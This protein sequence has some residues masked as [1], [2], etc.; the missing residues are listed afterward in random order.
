MAP[1]V[2]RAYRDR[3]HQ[4]AARNGACGEASD[5]YL[6]GR[7]CDPQFRE[8]IMRDRRAINATMILTIGILLIALIIYF[9]PQ[10]PSCTDIKGI[11]GTRPLGLEV[12][13]HCLARS[14]LLARSA[15]PDPAPKPTR[16]PFPPN[17]PGG[18]PANAPPRVQQTQVAPTPT[19]SPALP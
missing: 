8:P 14:G 9:S 11:G 16:L 10:T 15:G 4:V 6:S 18:L 12:V 5:T 3:A 1:L 7:P 17:M 2:A 13:I 19:G